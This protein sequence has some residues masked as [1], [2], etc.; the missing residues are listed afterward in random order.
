M[1]KQDHKHVQ[2]A[3][4]PDEYESLRQFADE[5]GLTVK[6]ATRE[7]LVEWVE[8]QRRVDPNDPAFTVL[9]E[10]EAPSTEATDARDE[11]D[12]VESWSGNQVDFDLADDPRPE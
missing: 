1:S 12:Q 11:D 3:L 10:L 2:T 7:A 6:E 4:E 8:R 5:R 9:D